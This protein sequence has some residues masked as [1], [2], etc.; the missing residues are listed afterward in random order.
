[1]SPVEVRV[2]F[3]F[4]G[5]TMTF[6]SLIISVSCFA[7]CGLPLLPHTPAL[8]NSSVD[9]SPPKAA[10]LIGHPSL[11]AALRVAGLDRPSHRSSFTR[12]D[13]TPD[14]AVFRDVSINLGAANRMTIGALTITRDSAQGRINGRL[15]VV[16]SNVMRASGVIVE[17]MSVETISLNGISGAINLID[18]LTSVIAR[19]TLSAPFNR[20]AGVTLAIAPAR[21][22]RISLINS[23]SDALENAEITQSGDRKETSIGEIAMSN[24]VL[25]GSVRSLEALT[26]RDIVI[27]DKKETLKVGHLSINDPNEAAWTGFSTPKHGRFRTDHLIALALGGATLE[28]L[29]LTSKARNASAQ[30]VR[31]MSLEI[32][33]LGGMKQGF[34]EQFGIT[35]LRLEGGTGANAW[36]FGLARLTLGSI[37]LRYLAVLGAIFTKS[38]NAAASNAQT[39]PPVQSDPAGTLKLKDVLTGG[40]LDGGIASFE[41]VD[42]IVTRGGARFNIDQI[43]L[44]QERNSAGIITAAELLPTQFRLA[45]N[46]PAQT[47]ATNQITGLLATLGR[48]DFT[49][50]FAGRSTFSP[51]TDILELD[52]SR[53]ELVG[54]GAIDAQ[55]AMSGLNQFMAQTSLADL[56]SLSTTAARPSTVS[57]AGQL[58]QLLAFY[59]GIY[60]NS[61]RLEVKE[62]GGLNKLAQMFA[63]G[64]PRGRNSA[65][66]PLTGEQLTQKREGWAQFFR[67]RAGDK[68]KSAI[69][70]TLSIAT[71][72]FLESGAALIIDVNPPIPIGIGDVTTPPS[73]R[74]RQLGLQVSNGP[75]AGQ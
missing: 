55:F 29:S 11:R 44:R 53:M 73:D 19:P 8:A 7:L 32:L 59:R 34:V 14:R 18:L 52:R 4:E 20:P 17:T 64:G 25:D 51:D 33:R 22:N 43:A 26:A 74:V 48:Q 63:A 42:L 15:S 1:M 21:I 35:G 57:P 66:A 24:V 72:R 56:V 41:L 50:I 62:F 36:E 69:E 6:R 16:A 10:T 27:D 39:P 60:L 2:N 12:V 45:W 23:K 54:W 9:S 38:F 65:Q 49:L 70:R 40:P 30:P 58:T 31:L 61:A 75:V 68:S 28:N 3:K 13:L 71:A 47:G 67:E 5:V 46:T 37:N